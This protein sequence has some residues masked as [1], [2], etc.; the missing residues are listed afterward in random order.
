MIDTPGPGSSPLLTSRI[1]WEGKEEERKKR[2]KER[3]TEK[4]GRTTYIRQSITHCSLIPICLRSRGV[5][6]MWNGDNDC[7]RGQ[8]TETDPYN[9]LTL[10]RPYPPPMCPTGPELLWEQ[11]VPGY[12]NSISSFV[13]L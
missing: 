3:G 13:N 1:C 7:S 10:A 5:V 9:I 4:G 11:E 6:T 12:C 2:E 8:D